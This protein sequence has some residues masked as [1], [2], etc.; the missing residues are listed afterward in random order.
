MVAD[1]VAEAQNS[2]GVIAT[3]MG[4]EHYACN[5]FAVS[6]LES[7]VKEAKRRNTKEFQVK[8]CSNRHD[9]VCIASHNIS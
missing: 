8:H 6:E 5:V 2:N 7:Q 4:L 9:H 3:E 1:G